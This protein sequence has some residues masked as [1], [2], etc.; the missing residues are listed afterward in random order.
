MKHRHDIHEAEGF[1]ILLDYDYSPDYTLR[2]ARALAILAKIRRRV[3]SHQK[4]GREL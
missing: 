2:W 1:T 3:S 4:A